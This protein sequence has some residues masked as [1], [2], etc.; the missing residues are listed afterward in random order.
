MEDDIHNKQQGEI[1]EFTI[2]SNHYTIKQKPSFCN[3]AP[4]LVNV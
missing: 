4:Y 1:V 2:V 3:L